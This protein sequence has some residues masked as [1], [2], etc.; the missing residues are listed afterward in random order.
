MCGLYRHRQ[1]KSK[2]VVED[3][4]VEVMNI[5]DDDV[6]MEDDMDIDKVGGEMVGTVDVIIP[7]QSTVQTVENSR[8]ANT[9]LP[10]SDPNPNCANVPSELD[11]PKDLDCPPGFHSSMRASWLRVKEERAELDG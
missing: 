8:K 1:S 5:D 2:N 10:A 4:L 11:H 9:V 3:T 6:G 7:K